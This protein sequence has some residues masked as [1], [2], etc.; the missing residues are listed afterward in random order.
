M[1]RIVQPGRLLPEEKSTEDEQ[2]IAWVRA[3]QH[4]SPQS[5]TTLLGEREG[6]LSDRRAFGTAHQLLH[7]YRKLEQK[8]GDTSPDQ[9]FMDEESERWKEFSELCAEVDRLAPPSETV[10]RQPRPKEESMIIL[11]ALPELSARLRKT[12]EDV[13]AERPGH[14]KVWVNAPE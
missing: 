13:L 4:L 1:P 8:S 7:I 11:A 10:P 9:P 2:I 5:Y 6:T 14:V 12:L 3:L